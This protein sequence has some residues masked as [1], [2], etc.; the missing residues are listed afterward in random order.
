[1]ST[2]E[3]PPTNVSL[4]PLY[5]ELANPNIVLQGVDGALLAF[6]GKMARL[7]QMLFDKLLVITSGRD[8][9]HVPGSAHYKGKAIDVRSQDLGESGELMFAACLA[10]S[11][12]MNGVCVYDERAQVP[13]GH[14]HLEVGV[15]GA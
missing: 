13:G 10:F 3:T 1:M 5:C 6:V 11:A 8:G 14:W 9:E 15:T 7:H 2:P 12:P 4:L